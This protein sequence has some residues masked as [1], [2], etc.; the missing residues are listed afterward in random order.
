M[1]FLLFKTQ[2]MFIS[3]PLFENV[4]KYLSKEC[5]VE[6][7]ERSEWG[8][9]LCQ[10]AERIPCFYDHYIPVEE[11]EKWKIRFPKLTHICIRG[12]SEKLDEY[13][14][15]Y[16]F[17]KVNLWR[18]KEIIDVSALT[19]VHTLNLS[20][21]AWITDVSALKNVHTLY[22]SYCTGIIDV[23]A[24]TNVHTLDLRWCTEVT[25]VSALTNVHTLCLNECTGITDVSALGQGALAQSC[26]SRWE[27]ARNVHTLNLERCTE[28]T[29]TSMLTNVKKLV[30]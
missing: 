5:F 16:P 14:N 24:L 7:V 28:V 27:L 6:T 11:V 19:N 3:L 10:E 21:C 18:C 8:K 23:S 30:L 9:H 15:W 26:S 29:D 12:W 2:T 22:L 25:D 13:T 1:Y 17:V 4:F 20:W